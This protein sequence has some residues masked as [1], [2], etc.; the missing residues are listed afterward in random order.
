MLIFL[1][2]CHGFLVLGF[3]IRILLR[4]DLSPPA[5]LAWFIVLNLLP[6]FGSATYFLFGEVD[7]GHRAARRYTHIFSKIRETSGHLTGDAASIDLLIDPLYRPAFAYAASI[8]GF[9]PVAGNHAQLQASAQD[10]IDSMVRDIDAARDHVHVL[11]YIW[12]DDGTG[13]A[14]A[15]ALIRATERGVTCRAMADG[16]GSRAMVGSALWRKM[17]QA[18]VR[19]AVSLPLN[20]P[21][22]TLLTS[23]LDLR[24]HRKITVID[25][26]ISYVGSRN[27]A[28]PEFRIK[29]KFAPW[30]DIMLCV[31][32]PA[33]VQNQL[34]FLSDWMAVTGENLMSLPSRPGTDDGG[35]PALVFG[36]GPTERRGATP[37]LFASLIACAR[38]DIVISTPYFVPDATLVEALRAAS[39]RGVDIKLIFP[40]RNDSWVVAAA[41]RSYYRT[42]LEAGCEIYEFK[43]GL[44]HAKTFTLD[45]LVTVVGS[46]NLDLRSFDLNYENNILLQDVAVTDDVRGRQFDYLAQSTQVTLT[47]VLDWSPHRRVWQNIVATVGPIL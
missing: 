17:E 18:G 20:N 24:N 25:G 46:S 13:T 42:L 15:E 43:G 28:D 33:V 38:R 32:G 41:S 4:D 21:L 6:Y 26:H 45:G 44:L 23:R 12:L 11:Y 9:Y 22:R 5:R 39:Y 30:V 31:T 35:F 40:R 1:A 29:P 7:I 47:H 36:D 34:L 3:T 10:T 2:I 16:L 19:M 37:Q 8:N 14:L 27:S